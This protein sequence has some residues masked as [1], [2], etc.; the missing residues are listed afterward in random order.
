MAIIGFDFMKCPV[1][2]IRSLH[3]HNSKLMARVAEDKVRRIV[4]KS[5]RSP[6]HILRNED[7]A[8]VGMM[9][10]RL[11]R[12]LHERTDQLAQLQSTVE[13]LEQRSASLKEKMQKTVMQ[14]KEQ[15]VAAK[16]IEITL[17][18]ELKE[19]EEKLATQRRAHEKTL[20][21][22]RVAEERLEREGGDGVRRPR[23]VR[24]PQPGEDPDRLHDLGPVD[25]GEALLR[26]QH[27]RR[28]P[29][30]LERGP[31]PSGG[32]KTFIGRAR[33]RPRPTLELLF[34]INRRPRVDGWVHFGSPGGALGHLF[35]HSFL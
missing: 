6:E 27:E 4:E 15:Q 7:P 8:V 29:D 22:R 13:P 9:V 21:D 12:E 16:Q 14:Q 3:K 28:L 26:L 10:E 32:P 5:T 24:R 35:L 25:Q 20:R 18:K 33:G 34:A 23:E 30:G 19:S 31:G 1:Q 17:R 2:E 11:S